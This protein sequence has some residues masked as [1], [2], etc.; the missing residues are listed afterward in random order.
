MN[1][2]NSKIENFLKEFDELE[3]LN[4]AIM[5]EQSEIDKTLSTFYHKVEGKEIK[6]VSESHNLIKELKVILNRRREN[7]LEG[8]LLRSTCDALRDKVKILRENNKNVL[9]KNDKV[10]TEIKERAK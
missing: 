8:L 4:A 5:K 1:P 9:I 2:I 10:L 6:H 7:K 3:T